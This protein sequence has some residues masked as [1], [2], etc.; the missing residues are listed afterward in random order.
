MKFSIIIPVYNKAFYL[1]ACINSVIKQTYENLEIIIINDGSSDNSLEI[2]EKFREIDRRIQLI[3]QHNQGVSVARNKGIESANGEWIYFLD[4]DDYLELN[5][6]E[7]FAKEIKLNNQIDLIEFGTKKWKDGVFIDQRIP[8]KK[9]I[10]TDSS[11]LILEN[12]LKPFSACLHLI[13]KELLINNDIQFDEDLKYNEDMLFMYKVFL[14]SQKTLV[15]DKSFYNIVFSNNSATRS[16][17]KKIQLINNLQYVKKL[18][19]YTNQKKMTNQLISDIRK[20]PNYFFVSFVFYEDAC[21]DLSEFQK[22]YNKIYDNHKEALNS[23]V[24]KLARIHF[25]LILVP[26]F[27]KFRIFKRNHQL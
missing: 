24:L 3:N 7:N 16:K 25:L 1:N 23:Q 4:A 13:K 20:T 27:L 2:C 12:E 15:L 26:L 19:D 21:K 11:K 18:I 8:S 5:A 22:L 10:F 17:V 9:Q 14:N 6:F